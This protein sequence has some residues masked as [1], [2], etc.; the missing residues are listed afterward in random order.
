MAFVPSISG[1]QRETLNS[2]GSGRL[3]FKSVFLSVF[4]PQAAP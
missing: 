3:E 2:L 4:A 1:P